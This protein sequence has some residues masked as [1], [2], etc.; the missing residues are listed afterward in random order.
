[1]A[2]LMTQIII[3][4]TDKASGVFQTIQDNAEKL[5]VGLVSV[6]AVDAFK[7]AVDDAA[8]FELQLDKVAAKGGYTAQEMDTLKNAAFDIGSKFGVS[9]TQAAEGLEI[10]A[11][12]GLN[13]KDSISTL[14]SVLGLAK[15]ESVSMDVAATKITD[16]LSIM[17]LGFEQ[18]G[19]GSDVLTKA[20]NLSNTS[21]VG[22]ADSIK[23]AGGIAKASGYSFEQTA[24][25]ID[26][27]ANSGLKGEQAG[28]GLRSVLT[29][30]KDPSS[31]ASKELDKLGISTRDVGEV[32]DALKSK[33][34]DANAAILGFGQEGAPAVYAFMDQGSAKIKNFTA[35]LQK[36]GGASK[37]TSDTM[38]A[39]FEGAKTRLSATFDNL[40]IKLGTPILK[41]LTDSSNQLSEQLQ[42]LLA[43]GTI[44]KVG[45]SL[46]DVF[47]AG[48]E[49]AIEFVKKTDFTAIGENIKDFAS[50]T[51]QTFQVISEDAR[52]AGN[53]VN[54]VTG[55]FSAGFNTIQA[56]AAI[57]EAGVV[58]ALGGM[59]KFFGQIVTGWGEIFSLLPGFGSVGE[60][61]KTLGTNLD[62]SGNAAIEF[63]KSLKDEAGKQLDE[64]AIGANKAQTAFG[65]LFNSAESGTK[66]LDEIWKVSATIK[67]T[68]TGVKDTTN[69]AA[70]ANHSLA[71]SSDTVKTAI[72][73]TGKK[74][75]EHAPKWTKY[76]DDLGQ[77]HYTNIGLKT[78]TDDVAKSSENA[79]KIHKDNET[80]YQKHVDDLGRV[81]YSQG[82]VA[83]K[84]DEA[85]QKT[86]ELS[87]S[88]STIPD[89]ETKITADA[90][91]AEN[92]IEQL[93][94]PT[95]SLHTVESNAQK[96]AADI[97]AI[98]Q[99]T[100]STHTFDSKADK[101]EEEI[102]KITTDTVSVHTFGSNAIAVNNDIDHITQ[103]T[104]SMHTFGSNALAPKT[105]I[106]EI[107]LDTI[108]LH[109]I[110]VDG[111][112]PNNEIKYITQPT[113][114]THTIYVQT[115][116]QN[117]NGGQIQYFADGGQPK[118]IRREGG[119]GG[120]GG[121]DT[122]P[123][124]LEPGEWIIKKEAVNKYGNAFMAQLNSMQ[125]Q[126]VPYFST[127]GSVSGV[128]PNDSS[129]IDGWDNLIQI[130]NAGYTGNSE[131]WRWLNVD[132][133][134]KKTNQ[135][136][137]VTPLKDWWKS[138]ILRGMFNEQL[139]IKK[140]R[141]KNLP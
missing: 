126:N 101:P 19:R 2:N 134:A 42:R 90:T 131:Y 41:P 88:I 29:S 99:D 87:A 36:A 138:N 114:S 44:D 8:K 116:Q 128:I 55:V 1:M 125:I 103:D 124:M 85:K 98:K 78:S 21:A 100:K 18:A 102:K 15:S 140:H 72:D 77:V 86:G 139:K 56:S 50:K 137:L 76:V 67:E 58:G 133:W 60:S 11:A 47:K 75:D 117:S 120:Y 45:Q 57:L 89:K 66:K 20:A 69:Q 119:L 70:Q 109:T 54:L 53:V 96:P 24:A 27:L 64:A 4:A 93:K 62:T 14:P 26:V 52:Q 63:A 97:S 31:T 30:L 9:G 107:K 22:V 130:L 48:G 71:E 118:F 6:L 113:S 135:Q 112:A 40:Q 92:K 10:L 83:K 32:M 65:E 132:D 46:A 38:A 28:T 68:L 127:G 73:A 80:T 5:A 3:N 91:Q 136:N 94:T 16:T 84:A 104:V 74:V 7:S 106:A 108:S 111:T 35:E 123:A 51:S 61:L 25:M 129:N 37:E 23:Y 95:G 82:E 110:G 33:G 105:D 39:N 59:N 49:W 81:S 115:I 34:K 121:G 43:D 13:A 12:A 141:N 122:V 17:G 79:A